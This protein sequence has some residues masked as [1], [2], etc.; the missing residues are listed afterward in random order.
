MLTDHM[1]TIDHF[2]KFLI[3]GKKILFS[4]MVNLLKS[5]VL[6]LGLAI[7]VYSSVVVL[8]YFHVSNTLLKNPAYFKLKIRS[9]V[10]LVTVHFIPLFS[11]IL[12][13]NSPNDVNE[14]CR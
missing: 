10:V 9:V 5:G 14:D 6:L 8:C 13:A 12:Q 11:S 2:F 3:H 4:F 1:L 7:S